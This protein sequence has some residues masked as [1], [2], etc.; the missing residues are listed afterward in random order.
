NWLLSRNGQSAYQRIFKE[1]DSLRIDIPKD[2]VPPESRRT[3]SVKYVEV[4]RADR[5]DMEPITHIV[6]EVWK[7][8]KK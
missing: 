1:P 6:N 3:D 8:G 7:N 4:D 2:A 5:M